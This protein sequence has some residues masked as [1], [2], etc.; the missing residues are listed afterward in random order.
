[1]SIQLDIRF[2]HPPDRGEG[3][4]RFVFAGLYV[5]PEDGVAFPPLL[6]GGRAIL[7]D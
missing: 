2:F 3:P 7:S 6:D 1:V 4:S 5:F